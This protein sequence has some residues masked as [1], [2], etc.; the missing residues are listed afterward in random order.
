[1]SFLEGMGDALDVAAR[2]P[3]DRP[4]PPPREV[5]TAW[6]A[7]WRFT[8]A[9]VAEGLGSLADIIKAYGATSA[10]TM[11]ADPM[12]RAAVGATAA[13]EGADEGRRLIDSGEALNSDVGRSF[14][15]VANDQYPDWTTATT[16]EQVLFGFGRPVV[17]LGIGA[18]AGPVGVFGAAVQ[19]GMTAADTLPLNVDQATRLKVGAISAVGMGLALLPVAGQ[20][21]RSTVPL[22]L[23]GGPGGFMAQQAA[24]SAILGRAGYAEIAKQYDPLDPLGLAVSTLVPLPFAVAGARGAARA[25]AGTPPKA[26][27]PP[28]SPE[29][30]DAAMTHNL[31]LLRDV[32][33]TQAVPRA[34]DEPLPVTE[35]DPVLDVVPKAEAETLPPTI[36]PRAAEPDIPTLI[37]ATAREQIAAVRAAGQTLDEFVVRTN[38]DA[39]VRNLMIGLAEAGGDTVRAARMLGDFERTARAHPTTAPE[40]IAADVVLASRDGKEVTP[41]A[42]AEAPAAPSKGAPGESQA[43]DTMQRDIS[44]DVAAVAPDLVV[45][46]TEDGRAI[47]SKELLDQARKDAAS[48]VDDADLG[49]L[50]A[51]LVEVA[52]KCFLINGA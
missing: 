13:K 41:E 34:A 37:A 50:D 16:A 7:P 43:G 33:E 6:S 9:A 29:H 47:T 32:Q 20:S 10:M 2:A 1:V 24:T 51:N 19:E 5:R 12:V 31:T 27:E 45:A 36:A 48:G 8:K 46:K 30:V 18:L 14:R 40:N 4:L 23:A 25:K 26:P 21:L 3:V 49:T 35:R 52:A 15:N 44:R 38:P 11:E 42:A 17:K 28:S 39:P 22:Y